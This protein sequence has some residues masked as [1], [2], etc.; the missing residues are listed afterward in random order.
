M[1]PER[2]GVRKLLGGSQSEYLFIVGANFIEDRLD[3][4][5]GRGGECAGCLRRGPAGG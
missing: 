5:R 1:I 3:C 2:E 4:V